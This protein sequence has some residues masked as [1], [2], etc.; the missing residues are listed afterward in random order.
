MS[1]EANRSQSFEFKAEIQQLLNI[2]VHS[3]YTEREIFLRELISNA[4]DALNRLQFEMLTTRDVV[5]PDAELAIRLEADSEGRTITVSDTGVGMTQDEV[6]QDLG[7]I[8]HSGAAAFLKQL[9][10]EKRPGVEMIGQFGVGF[11]SVFM[12]AEEVRVISRS[13]KP[14]AEAVEWVSD[15]GSSYRVGPADKTSRGTR[16]EIKLKEDA[17]DLVSTWRLEQI[18]K[19]HSDF[20]QFPIYIGDK[21]EAVNRQT[22]PWRKA[23]REVTEEQYVEFYKHLTLD[24][25]NPLLTAHLVT[26]APANVRAILY[27][28]SR[29]ERGVLS[30]RTDHGL[31]LYVRNVLIQE[32][33][34]DLLPNAWRFVE[35]VVES[36]DLPLNISRE[37]VQSSPAARRIQ[38]A[39]VRK[40][41]KELETMAEERP[42][43]YATFWREFGP[44]LKEGVATDPSSH[45]DLLPL[46]RF[47]SSRDGG[48]L[49]SLRQYVERMAEDQ[50]AIYYLIG[51]D[52]KS[53][54]RSPHLDYFRAHDL[55]VLY[56]VDPIDSFMAVALREFEGKPLKN[57]D[58]AGLDLDVKEEA[59]VD[60][61]VA[62]ADLNRLI[63]RF[64]KV[65]DERVLEVRESRVLKDNPARLVSP[66]DAPARE[67]SRV[68]RMLG[69][70]Y[71]VPRRILELNR[72]HPIVANLARLVTETPESPVID[73]S[74]ELLFES[75][76][77]MEGLHPNPTDM[78]PR[79]QQ[80]MQAA[81][82][83]G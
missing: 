81:T 75:Q 69:Q 16:I 21:K 12:V 67:M 41:V 64:V 52:E 45:G 38:R 31:Q 54:A 58:D 65:L 17:A 29:R 76:L 23:P 15:G 2:L 51:E 39:L 34:K 72:S 79:L 20:V 18:V 50:Q 13:Y 48:E 19:K 6:V 11:Y 82:A 28:P 32:Y 7:T 70:E 46:L 66:D 43:D 9:Q 49:V 22:A 26:D 1:E 78:I 61:A 4:S 77:L 63:S 33:N 62:E 8:A 83:R 53:A 37:T 57:V 5:D 36:E 59:P 40:L 30:L 27:V 44:F 80:L 68:Y 55:E 14:E 73:D 24:F 47:H 10:E 35:G 60:G 3:L 74:I 42:E 25:E 56:L 71:E